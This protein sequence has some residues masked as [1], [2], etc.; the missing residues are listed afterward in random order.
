LMKAKAKMTEASERIPRIHAFSHL[1]GIV[2][3]SQ[4]RAVVSVQNQ[5]QTGSG[6]FG[7]VH[8]QDFLSEH[9]SAKNAKA[10]LSRHVLP[11]LGLNFKPL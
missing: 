1:N 5:T 11:F 7:N 3:P 9:L 2:D 8:K 6:R 4:T 10:L